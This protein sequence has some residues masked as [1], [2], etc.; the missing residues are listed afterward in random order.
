MGRSRPIRDRPKVVVRPRCNLS[1]SPYVLKESLG[2]ATSAHTLL[3]ASTGGHLEELVHLAPRLRPSSKEISWVTHKDPQVESLLQ[4]QAVRLAPYV[5]PRGF[6][7][8]AALVP[9]ARRHLREENIDR[10]VST[11]AGVALAYFIAAQI[12]GTPCH[13]IESAARV[14]GPSLTGRVAARLRGIDLYTQYPGWANR[15]WHYRGSVFDG[16]RARQDAS[17]PAVHRVVVTLGTMRGY[18][19][20][21]MV[22]RL[23]TVLPQVVSPD[24]EFWWQTGATTGRELP[25]RVHAWTTRAELEAAISTAD[26]VITHAGVGSALMSLGAGK[27]PLLVPRRARFGEHVDDHQALIA[28]ELAERG[29]AVQAEA[30][31][32]EATDLLDAAGGH[33]E[34]RSTPPDF[35]LGLGE[36]T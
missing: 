1:A 9:A 33:V 20:H 28:D 26:L 2:E 5:P 6:K 36:P 27:R 16:Y 29:L 15:R 34:Q 24:A 32:I 18:G 12:T 21:R 4:G 19:F 10:V 13:Y 23:L 35:Q 17:R 30:S 11:G 7:P 14:T 25:G 3:V 8:L 31:F 22:D